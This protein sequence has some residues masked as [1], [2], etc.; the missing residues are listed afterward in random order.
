MSQLRAF[1]IESNKLSGTFPAELGIYF[2]RYIRIC[3]W[4]MMLW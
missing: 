3:D 4:M 2:L 1:G